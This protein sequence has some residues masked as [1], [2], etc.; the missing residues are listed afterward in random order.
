[1]IIFPFHKK[2]LRLWRELCDLF[3]AKHLEI[4]GP[5][6]CTKED[7]LGNFCS[8]TK[9]WLIQLASPGSVWCLRHPDTALPLKKRYESLALQTYV[10]LDSSMIN[11]KIFLDLQ[12]QRP[13]Q[14]GGAVMGGEDA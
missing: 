9:V 6:I 10:D 13:P 11:L 5:R 3:K 2:E 4:G 1:M 14:E 7:Q 12:A 8:P